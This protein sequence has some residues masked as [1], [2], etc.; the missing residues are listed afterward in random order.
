MRIT[1]EHLHLTGTFIK[2]SCLN[3]TLLISIRVSVHFSIILH[4]RK[5]VKMLLITCVAKVHGL[6]NQHH[7]LF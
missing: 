6:D 4:I 1:F 3:V 5:H 2:L 7:L